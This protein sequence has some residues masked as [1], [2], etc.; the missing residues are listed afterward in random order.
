MMSGAFW[1]RLAED[2]DANQAGAV[3]RSPGDDP[4]VGVVVI[5]LM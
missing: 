4:A 5:M 1:R 2:V 3:P